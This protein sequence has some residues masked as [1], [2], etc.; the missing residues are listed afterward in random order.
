MHK[1]MGR[2]HYTVELPRP[3]TPDIADRLNNLFQW[4]NQGSQP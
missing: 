3:V 4:I 1:T 2:G